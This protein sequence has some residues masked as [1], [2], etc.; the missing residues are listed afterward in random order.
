LNPISVAPLA[1]SGADLVI[2]VP[3]DSCGTLEFYKA[4]ELIEIGKNLTREKL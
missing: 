2:E 1:A 3:L 4:E